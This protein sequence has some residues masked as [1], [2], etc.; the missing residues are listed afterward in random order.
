MA[1]YF[2]QRTVIWQSH[3]Q[4]QAAGPAGRWTREQ[5]IQLSLILDLCVE[6]FEPDKS[7]IFRS[8]TMSDFRSL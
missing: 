4:Q 3:M 7:R 6:Q 1:M 5:Q 2:V 8:M